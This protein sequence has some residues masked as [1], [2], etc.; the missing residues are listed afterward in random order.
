MEKVTYTIPWQYITGGTSTAP[1][2]ST[3]NWPD[4]VL[5]QADN[6]ITYSPVQVNGAINTWQ[7]IQDLIRFAAVYAAGDDA[8]QIQLAQSGTLAGSIWTGGLAPE[9]TPALTN[10]YPVRSAKLAECLN[11]CLRPHPGVFTEIDYTTTPPTLH[12]RNRANMTAITLPYKS[13][14]AA[15]IKHLAS[16]IKSL[17]E[18]VPDNVRLFYRING[19]FNGAPIAAFTFDNYP[20][21][22]NHLLSLDFSIDITG[23]T[24][25]QTIVNFAS[26]AFDPTDLTLWRKKLP[27]LRQLSQGGQIPNDGDTGALAFISAAAYGVGNLKGI[28]VVDDAGAA[29]NTAVYQYFT[30]QEVYTW[31]PFA[32]KYA[33]VRAFFSYQKTPGL[34]GVGNDSIK[35][36]EHHFRVLLTNAASGQYE[37]D[38]L[39]GTAEA[40]PPNLAR[41]IYTELSVLQWKL[42]HEILQVAADATLVPTLI[43]PGRHMVNLSG[44][45]AAWTTMN[46]VPE[47]VTIDLSRT[48]DGKLMAHH[49]IS[50]GPVNH[51]E[52]GY[53][54]ELCNFFWNRNRSG[55]DPTQ[56]QSGLSGNR[57]DLSSNGPREN[58]TTSP[59]IPVVTNHA[60]VDGGGTISGV[61]I[62]AKDVA[63]GDALN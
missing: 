38:Q 26:S 58:S 8:V 32:V 27:S 59:A 35:E 39:Q 42:T 20:T 55:I 31:M 7:Q 54:I 45:N 2:Y 10:W 57:V 46:A 13:T 52:P 48:A 21:N 19:T 36:Q 15:G 24:R 3:F 30:D 50:C 29:I 23:T 28:Q 25:T 6:T 40:I 1:T 56:R 4:I 34:N 33:T 16:D 41:N 60:Y 12:F 44:G 17:D 61:K 62:S 53:L 49:K 51:L 9:F 37:F 43:K 14:D 5:F 63:N 11:I 18:L 22:A 47:N